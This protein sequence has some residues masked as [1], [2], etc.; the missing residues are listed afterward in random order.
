MS[1]QASTS[2]VDRRLASL[3]MLD[4]REVAELLR[5]SPR[6]VWRLVALAEARGGGFPRPLRLGTR[7]VRWRLGD[8]ERYVTALAGDD[9]P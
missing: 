3:T 4:V 5:V 2:D 6:Q 1:T 7:T 9:R 8:I